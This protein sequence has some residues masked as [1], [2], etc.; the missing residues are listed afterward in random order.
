[1]HKNVRIEPPRTDSTTE[2]P[3][4]A[5]A[6][7][8]L[9]EGERFSLALEGGGERLARRAA[10]CLLVPRPGDRVL[11][12]LGAEAFVLAVLEQG[13][14]RPAEVLFEGDATIRSRTGRIDVD[15]PEGLR[16][17][18][19][20]TFEV[21]SRAVAIASG[22]AELVLGEVSAVA[23]I[24]RASFDDAGLVART[25]DVVAERITERAE[26]VFR[27]VSE[28]DQLRARH[29]DYRAE[30]SAQIKGENTVVVA[31]QVARVD[32]AQVHIG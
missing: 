25:F 17:S 8:V 1:M 3:R 6:R 26:R 31:R 29:F 7:V 30:H 15:A 4:L 20:R 11:V 16:V 19:R 13:G 12:D 24:A 5:H 10:S 18:T 14:E 9:T 27:F 22:K 21:V 2:A 28:M 23:A 32:G